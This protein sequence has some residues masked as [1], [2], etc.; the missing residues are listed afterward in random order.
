MKTFVYIISSI[1]FLSSCNGQQKK[2]NICSSENEATKVI[3]ELVEVKVHQRYIDSLTQHT[4]G[5]SYMVEN[6]KING[7]DYYQIKTGYNG[8][9]HWE[10]YNIFYV[11]KNDCGKIYVDDVVSG[12]IITLQQW[13]Q[14]QPKKHNMKTKKELFSELFNE[15]SNINFTP[16]DLNKENADIKEFKRKL[17]LFEAQKPDSHDFNIDDL[18]LLI[19]NETFTNNEKYINSNWLAYFIK[20]YKMESDKI[21][22]LMTLALSQEDYN[23]VKIILENESYIVSSKQLDYA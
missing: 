7:K 16:N 6:E 2:K 5:V 3:S 22:A 15:G 20:K 17:V 23:A 13:R 21:Y 4:R 18:A 19:N 11:N 14:Q 9:L 1:V 8:K 12:N 10:T